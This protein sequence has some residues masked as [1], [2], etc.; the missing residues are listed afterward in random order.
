[1]HSL[2]TTVI[3]Y[4]VDKH[5]KTAHCRVMDLERRTDYL[6]YNWRGG[7]GE[8]FGFLYYA[9]VFGDFLFHDNVGG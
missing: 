9:H 2:F 3:F 4:I 1:M 5:Q 6:I 8:F 7:E